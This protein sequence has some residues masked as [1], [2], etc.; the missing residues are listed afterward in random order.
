MG[1]PNS[2]VAFVRMRFAEFRVRA[3]GVSLG[4]LLCALAAARV[5]PQNPPRAP[6]P[7]ENG[8]ELV[9][10][11]EFSRALLRGVDVGEFRFSSVSENI[12]R[13]PDQVAVVHLTGDVVSKGLFPRIAGFHFHQHIESTAD[14][15]PF[16]TLRTVRSEEQGKRQRELEGVF[17]HVAH[18][19]VWTERRPNQQTTSVD[20]SEP[21]QDVLTAIYYLR[22]RELAPGASFEIPLSDSGRMYHITVAVKESKE[23]NT[24]VGHVRTIRIEPGLF[25]DNAPVRTRGEL[26]IW[27]TDDERRLP[28]RA[29]LKLDIG[30]FD[31]KLKQVNSPNRPN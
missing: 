23:M 14:L 11:A 17:D 3:L 24:A 10:S 28:V 2:K 1:N 29:Q 16:T 22:T 20:F 26:S 9:Y 15:T 21:I 7:F 4:M 8:E 12:S 6:L 5:G 30:T 31:I 25:G 27:L 18:K 13:G 19:A